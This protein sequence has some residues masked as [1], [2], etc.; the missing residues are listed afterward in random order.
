MVIGGAKIYE[1]F[2]PKA[3]HLII[4]KIHDQ[5]EGD[6][7]FPKIEFE[8]WDIKRLTNVPISSENKD[9]SFDF[10]FYEKN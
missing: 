1:L 10:I 4:T 9:C 3:T 2:M 8:E 7:Y 6:T 5:F